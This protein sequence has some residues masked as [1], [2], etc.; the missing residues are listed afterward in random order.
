ME[1]FWRRES[2]LTSPRYLKSTCITAGGNSLQV[3][4][5]F[6]VPEFIWVWISYLVFTIAPGPNNLSF[7]QVKEKENM[8]P[9]VE[10]SKS[11]QMA[12][13]CPRMNWVRGGRG[14]GSWP[15][16]PCQENQKDPSKGPERPSQHEKLRKY[17]FLFCKQRQRMWLSASSFHYS[18]SPNP[19]QNLEVGVLKGYLV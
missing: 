13:K 19:W 14:G 2:S 12:N 11:K 9:L 17:Q 7:L 18:R 8:F 16:R 1:K 6:P 5:C 10:G 15:L 3:S 4:N